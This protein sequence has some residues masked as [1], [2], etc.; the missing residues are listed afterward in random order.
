MEN[1]GSMANWSSKCIIFNTC[2][3][4]GAVYNSS[5]NALNEVPE[6]KIKGLTGSLSSYLGDSRLQLT[7]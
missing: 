1:Q 5:E 3:W 2:G 4:R 6:L 7:D